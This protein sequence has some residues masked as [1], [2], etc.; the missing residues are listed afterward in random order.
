MRRDLSQEL[1]LSAMLKLEAK[2]W[3]ARS[4][5][6]LEGLSNLI[7]QQ[8]TVWSLHPAEREVAFLLLKGLSL[9]DI[10]MLRE[11]T[12]KTSRVQAMAI[13]AKAGLAGRSELS[14]FFKTVSAHFSADWQVG[15]KSPEFFKA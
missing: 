15:S 9:K 10:A 6:Y 8:L 1:K 5:S 7:D 11:T 2:Q 4:K 14:A 13:Y 3:Q 12:E